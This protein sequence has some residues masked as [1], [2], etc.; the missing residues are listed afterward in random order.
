[1][2]TVTTFGEVML[3]ISPENK[4]ERLTQSNTFRI[5]PGGSES[6]VSIAIKNLGIPTSFVTKLPINELSEKAIQFLQ[7]FNVDTSKIVKQGNKLGIY[8]T[9]N[10]IGP[11]NSNV[12]YDRENTSFSEVKVS[13]FNWKEIF[14]NSGWFHFSGISPSISKNVYEVLLDAIS[15]IDIPYSIDLNYRSKLWKWLKKDATLIKDVMT[16]LCIGA[17]LIAGNESDFQNIFGFQ[18]TLNS[19]N[20]SFDEIAQKCFDMFPKLKY[21]SISNR[22]AVSAS[23]N[24]WNGF[25]F[26]RNDK[27]FKYTGLEYKLEPIEDRV[28]TG[29]SFVSGIIFGLINKSNYSYQEII[30]F[31]TTL[32][33]LNH[34][35][36][37]DASRFTLN[38]V[39]E[40]VK[41]NGTG[42]IQR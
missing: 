19:E 13:D 17:T 35:T 10:G 32:S 34:T 41:N 26:V 31:S 30:N 39:L 24:I 27:Q 3:R 7:Q 1:M 5:E 15:G 25:L 36:M 12:I 20:A 37:G 2:K 38:D 22:K 18:Q 16:N 21:I 4:G 42:R 11:R 33:A 29:D 40:V 8:W 14:K 23:S 6:N 9:E 28:G